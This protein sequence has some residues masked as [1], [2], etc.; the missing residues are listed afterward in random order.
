MLNKHKIHSSSDHALPESAGKEGETHVD[1]D[2]SFL[3]QGKAPKL[4]S[5]RGLWKKFEIGISEKEFQS[6]RNEMW[7]AF[8]KG[9]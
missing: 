5:P 2:M 9:D 4:M 1:V 7:G 6:L 8:S 3:I